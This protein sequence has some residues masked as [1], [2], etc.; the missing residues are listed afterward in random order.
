ML[1]HSPQSLDNVDLRLNGLSMESK[2]DQREDDIYRN[3]GFDSLRVTS[4][5]LVLM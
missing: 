3:M 4:L 2:N 5:S 1:R